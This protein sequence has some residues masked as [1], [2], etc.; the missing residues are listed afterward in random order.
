VKVLR[1]ISNIAY[2]YMVLSSQN[3][4]NMNLCFVDSV[5]YRIVIIP[6]QQTSQ[7]SFGLRRRMT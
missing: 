3:I 6:G 4:I 1:D 2:F 7:R 5:R